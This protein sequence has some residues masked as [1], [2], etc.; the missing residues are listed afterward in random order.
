[1]KDYKKILAHLI[2]KWRKQQ[3][4]TLY[5]ISKDESVNV[6]IETLQRI[7]KGEEVRTD[8]LLKYLHYCHAHGYDVMPDVWNYNDSGVSADK[9]IV[10]I[11]PKE[12]ETVTYSIKE[13][14]ID[15]TV[16]IKTGQQ[17]TA[18]LAEEN[19]IEVAPD[20]PSENYLD[21]VLL[22]AEEKFSEGKMMDESDQ[23]IFVRNGRCPKCG[24]A[25]SFTPMVSKK[26]NRYG[27]C[28]TRNCDYIFFGSADDPQIEFNRKKG[29][30]PLH[31]VK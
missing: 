4:I 12:N 1:M 20:S 16:D 24:T 21:P 14:A 31:G 15:G 10:S 6:R 17:S 27:K 28:T 23:I 26:G 3:G 8:G 7:E 18:D 19:N 29:I 30:L 9:E 11:L 22:A 25:N 5:Q 13:G 2:R